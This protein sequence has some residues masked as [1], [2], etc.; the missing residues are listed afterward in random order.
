M[1]RL[2]R[3]RAVPRARGWRPGRSLLALLTTGMALLVL[4]Q[5]D[6]AG[7]YT[8]SRST[9]QI[10]A[11]SERLTDITVHATETMTWSSDG[12]VTVK[13]NVHNSGSTRKWYYVEAGM[14]S[15]ATSFQAWYRKSC[16][17]ID[18]DHETT[19]SVSWID[20]LLNPSWS[21]IRTDPGLRAS[22][23]LDAFRVGVN[24]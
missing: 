16:L 19:W 12:R 1:Q 3:H 17:R 22:F 15:P 6:P 5:A 9:T 21:G 8:L 11:T 24:C 2:F 13:V 20:P 14:V 4:A 7:A 18:G 23:A 10:V